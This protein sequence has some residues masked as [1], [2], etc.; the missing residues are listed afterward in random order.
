MGIVAIAHSNTRVRNEENKTKIK[1]FGQGMKK[2][3]Q[4]AVMFETIVF[5]GQDYVFG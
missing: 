3:M 1:Q 4:V 5:Y 2:L